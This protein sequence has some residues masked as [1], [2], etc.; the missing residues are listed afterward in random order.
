MVQAPAESSNSLRFRKS[1]ASRS[2]VDGRYI[3]SKV[4]SSRGDKMLLVLM[5]FLL[6][7]HCAIANTEK[8]IFLGPEHLQVPLEHPTLEDLQL[9]ALSPQHWTLRTHIEAEFPSESLK[10]G[11]SSW[12][13][14]HRLQEGQRYEVRI[15]WAATVSCGQPMYQLR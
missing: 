12:Y 15:C 6:Q 1:V 9:D 10:Y 8:V 3:L 14:L 13:L 5:L 11:H 4:F 2:Y 7:A